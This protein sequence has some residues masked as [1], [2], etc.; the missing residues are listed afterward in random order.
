MAR[1]EWLHEV[2]DHIRDCTQDKGFVISAD[3]TRQEDTEVATTVS[4]FNGHLDVLINNASSI[5]PSPMPFT[6]YR[7][8]PPVITPP[9]RTIS[10]DQEGIAGND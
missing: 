2:R 4:E 7:L 6:D 10:P 3:L 5:G 9:D 8:R 1:V